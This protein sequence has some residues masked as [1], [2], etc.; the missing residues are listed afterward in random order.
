MKLII[1]PFTKH[2]I[3]VPLNPPCLLASTPAA[4]PTKNIGTNPGIKIAN[5][6]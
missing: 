5:P 2:P 4:A 6:V 3:I 1:S